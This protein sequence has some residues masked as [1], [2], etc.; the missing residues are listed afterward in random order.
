MW[1]VPL[2]AVDTHHDDV[3]IDA[4]V[5]NET[6]WSSVWRARTGDRLRC[7]GC[8]GS[9]VAKRM[10]SSG[11]RFFAHS[12]TTPECPSYGESARHLHLKGRFAEAFRAVGWA[13]EVEATGDGWRA[14][15]L[16]SDP[17]T[18]RRVAVEVQLASITPDVVE[19]RMSRH[20]ASDVE[21]LWVFERNRPRW[22]QAVP[23]ALIDR[24]DAVFRTVLV[25]REEHA[26]P[27]LARAA[28]ILQF[29]TR[30]SEGRLRPVVDPEGFLGGS[31]GWFPDPPGAYFQ[32]DGCVDRWLVRA[33]AEEAERRARAERAEEARRREN[34][35]MIAS[36]H[37]FRGWFAQHSDLHVW[38]GGGHCSEP[39]DA[40]ERNWDPNVG[41]SICIGKNGPA[42]VLALAEPRRRGRRVDP[43]V[44]AWTTGTDPRT[45]TAGFAEVY[46][47]SS[48]ID[49]ASADLKPFV[50][51]RR[52]YW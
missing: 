44:A 37:A 22:G 41:I 29:A 33:R 43:R 30:F 5:A 40:V 15:V 4:T 25:P 48:T 17:A 2:L 27:T 6:T 46:T 8:G 20:A 12:T 3:I 36:L 18:G 35:P 19:E 47:P 7:R 16:V 13:V 28:T 49:L 31:N 14:D 50:R 38:F 26:H 1:T 39:E 10:S 23:S 11:L 34:E 32:V 24:D 45:R 52:R 21:T 9:L 51:R 42:F